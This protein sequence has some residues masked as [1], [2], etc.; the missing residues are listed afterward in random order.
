MIRG[1]RRCRQ[2]MRHA[3]RSALGIVPSGIRRQ[4]SD[5]PALPHCAM[6]I[7]AGQSRYPCHR[8]R[9]FRARC[10]RKHRFGDRNDAF[11]LFCS[12]HH[13]PASQHE[14][15]EK[16]KQKYDVSS[17]HSEKSRKCTTYFRKYL[18][19]IKF[20][21]TDSHTASGNPECSLIIHTIA[22]TS[23]FRIRLNG[24]QGLKQQ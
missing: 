17:K 11:G 13:I 20:H 16:R 2:K 12:R 4:D 7:R 10:R 22:L 3:L 21:A 14:T 9:H 15:A 24:F 19:V 5:I 23:F 18:F 1:Q 8:E 6:H